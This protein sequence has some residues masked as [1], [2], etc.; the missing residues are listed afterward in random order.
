MVLVDCGGG[1]A[2]DRFIES[3]EEVVHDRQ[4]GVDV[5]MIGI[6]LNDDALQA[7]PFPGN[8]VCRDGAE[9]IREVELR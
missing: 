5:W 9:G 7:E 2:I 1:P 4:T 8:E 6:N 3:L